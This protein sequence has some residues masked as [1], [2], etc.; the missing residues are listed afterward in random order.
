VTVHVGPAHH[1]AISAALA[2]RSGVRVVLEEEFGPADLV[3]DSDAGSV[4]ARLNTRVD[5]VERAI[6]SSVAASLGGGR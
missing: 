5:G 4:D 2:E 1:A 3:V 6:R